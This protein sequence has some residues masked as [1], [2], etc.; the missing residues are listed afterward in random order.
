[1]P[2]NRVI[3][4]PKSGRLT[5]RRGELTTNNIQGCPGLK[6]AAQV[7]FYQARAGAG[8]TDHLVY[9]VTNP[10]GKVAPMM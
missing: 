6:I 4:A 8:G 3:E 2:K 7:A 5:V 1:M 10:T 9:A